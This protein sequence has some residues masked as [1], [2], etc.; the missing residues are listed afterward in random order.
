MCFT[1]QSVALR[2][3]GGGG[4]AV[5]SF[6]TT[7]VSGWAERL[8]RRRQALGKFTVTT[9]SRSSFSLRNSTRA[10]KTRHAS[11]YSIPDA[12]IVDGL[13]RLGQPVQWLEPRRL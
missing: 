6:V 12:C 1:S 2:A 7:R 10:G 13:R 9:D 11:L 5:A 3:V 8:Q 4:R